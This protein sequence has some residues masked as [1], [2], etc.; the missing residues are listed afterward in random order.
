MKIR[1]LR[2]GGPILGAEQGESLRA[3]G[4]RALQALGRGSVAY[5]HAVADADGCAAAAALLPSRAGRRRGGQLRRLARGR[6]SSAFGRPS[7][8]SMPLVLWGF[9]RGPTLTLTCLMEAT[10][11]FTKTGKRFVTVIG[12]ARR[13]QDAWTTSP[14]P[15]GPSTLTGPSVAPTWASSGT[16]APGC[17]TSRWTRCPCRRKI[18]CDLVHLDLFELMQEYNNLDEA[19]AIDLARGLARRP[20]EGQRGRRRSLQRVHGSTSPCER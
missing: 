4:F 9:G 7:S 18:G 3:E 6:G 14:R 13:R 8:A 10:S 1:L 5:P 16:P 11:D 20:G 17:W 2:G 19:A 12:D 15:C